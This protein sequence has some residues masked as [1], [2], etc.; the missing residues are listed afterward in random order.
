VKER[1]GKEFDRLR[2]SEFESFVVKEVGK[3]ALIVA[4]NPT[5][6]E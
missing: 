1:V 3:D 6:R 4:T 2:V 5:R